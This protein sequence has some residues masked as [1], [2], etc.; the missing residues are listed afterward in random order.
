M[1]RRKYR[2]RSPLLIRTYYHSRSISI[3]ASNWPGF[4][5]SVFRD[6]VGDAATLNDGNIWLWHN[7]LARINNSA[8][9][10]REPNRKM[11]NLF[12]LRDCFPDF[13]GINLQS[14][15]TEWKN[16]AWPRQHVNWLCYRLPSD[17]E[18]AYNKAALF[19]LPLSVLE[20]KN[21][22]YW[23]VLLKESNYDQK[24]TLIQSQYIKML[25][26]RLN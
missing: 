2:K 24:I 26:K 13:P 6:G 17:Y 19:L 15:G 23:G 25:M 18:A 22:R 8:T 21:L 20:V 9:V 12:L 4:S 3:R 5:S 14:Q 1:W 7:Q 11:T 10:C 16:V